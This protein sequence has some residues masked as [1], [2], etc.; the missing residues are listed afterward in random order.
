MRNGYGIPPGTSYGDLHRHIDAP[1]ATA[2]NC[3]EKCCS[4]CE[5]IVWLA[6]ADKW[7][8][9]MCIEEEWIEELSLLLDTP[10]ELPADELWDYY[11]ACRYNVL[12]TE[13][14]EFTGFRIVHPDPWPEQQITLQQLE[15]TRKDIKERSQ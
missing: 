7:F 11:E 4:N 12:K 10:P 8:S 15:H 5:R 14:D 1:E 9:R 13:D 2:H 3:E 6:D